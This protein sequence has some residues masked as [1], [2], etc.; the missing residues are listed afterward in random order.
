MG[1]CVGDRWDLGMEGTP[2]ATPDEASSH[3]AG[4]RKGALVGM[5]LRPGP[6]GGRYF[7][8][9][10]NPPVR[11]IPPPG[12]L[13]QKSNAASLPP[14]AFPKGTVCIQKSR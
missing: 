3:R 13:G 5:A 1:L 4:G 6:L 2:A 9:L 8:P 10:L 11:G 7:E 14:I 12:V